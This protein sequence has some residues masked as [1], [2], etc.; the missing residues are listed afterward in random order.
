VSLVI[1]VADSLRHDAAGCC[2]GAARTPALDSL[3]GS[4]ILFER[5]I[6]AAPWT[7]PSVAAMLTGV[8]AHRLGLAKWEQPWPERHPSLFDLARKSGFEVGSFVFD[9]SHL[10]S[11][12]PA[13]GVAGSSQDVE[14][15][16][17]WLAA[18]RNERFVAFVHYWWTHVPYVDKPMSTGAWRAAT[19]RVL[20]AMRSGAAARDGARRLYLRAVERFSEQFLARL[21]DVLDLDSTWLAIL[22]DHGEGFGERQEVAEL[23][24]VFDLHGNTLYEEVLRVPLVLRPPGGTAAR[25]VP[26]L[27]RTVDLAPT[28]AELAELGAWPDQAAALLD[29]VSLAA[30]VNQSAAPPELDA[31]SAKN[32]DFVDLPQL[33]GEASELWDGFALTSRRYKQIWHP[34]E[35][36]RTAF[37]LAADPGETT[38]IASSHGNE[39]AA[40]WSRLER[41]LGRA[42]VGEIEPEDVERV[43]RRLRG[44]GYIDE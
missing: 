41:E 37:D 40:G 17:A 31:V 16:F 18:R 3:A 4:G 32:R 30:C 11:R 12:V 20:Q 27:V 35:D 33:P 19:E 15:M 22:S 29:G 9:P 44:L 28:L 24:D 1:L 23:A 13:A 26:E 25:C 6:S 36:R 10:F 43:R 2:G 38:D 14:P 7:V 42:R 21:V 5:A 39:L 8:F 34:V